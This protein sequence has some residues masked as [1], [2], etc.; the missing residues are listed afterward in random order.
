MA[1]RPGRKCT[2]ARK[3]RVRRRLA[4]ASAGGSSMKLPIL[5]SVAVFLI[6]SAP[7][8]AGE[9]SPRGP[10]AATWAEVFARMRPWAG[11][12]VAGSDPA[13]LQGKILCGYQGWFSTPGDGSNVAASHE[14]PGEGWV[15]YGDG[16][17]K[18]GVCNKDLWPDM[19]EAGA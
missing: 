15:H 1:R 4:R 11:K 7:V 8:P 12:H 19:S 6:S 9:P 13:G 18:P 3:N 2:L 17:F 10:V 16:I 14:Q 5:L